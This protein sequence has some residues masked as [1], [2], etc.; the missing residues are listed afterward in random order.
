METRSQTSLGRRSATVRQHSS[1]QAPNRHS[2]L[3][4]I[5]PSIPRPKACNGNEVPDSAGTTIRNSPPTFVIPAPTVIPACLESRLRSHGQKRAEETRSQTSL[6]RR[7]TR[8]SSLTPRHSSLS[9]ISPAIPRPKARNGNEF[10]DAAGTTIRNSPP[11]VGTPAPNRHSSSSGISPA[12][13]RPKAHYGNE[14]PDSAGT[15]DDASI[16]PH[17]PSFQLVWNL[18]C[19]PTAKSAQWKRG[20]RLRWDDGSFQPPPSFQLVWNP[21]CHPTARSAQWKRGPSRR[22]DD[23]PQQS[24]NDRHSRPLTVIPARLE[25]RPA[26]HGQKRAMKTR[27][28]TPLGRR[29]TG[30]SSP[31]RHSSL[32]GISPSIP[33]P[34]AR[35]ENEVLNFAGKT[36]L[37]P[38][39]LL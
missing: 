33:R 35:N 37:E 12:I 36:I 31:H 6:G 22:W 16:Q 20:P 17:S 38:L 29:T 2:S 27:S 1:F 9:G 23:D 10:P 11:T 26:S 14:V 19:Y 8:Q 32:S 34:K 13:P 18:A 7:T 5:S 4:G 3:S 24:A 15:M 28:Q 25:S 39:Q 21:A 30:H